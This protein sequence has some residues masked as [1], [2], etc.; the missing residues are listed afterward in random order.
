MPVHFHMLNH[1]CNYIAYALCMCYYYHYL[2]FIFN[3]HLRL[4]V[5]ERVLCDEGIILK[6]TEKIQKSPNFDEVVD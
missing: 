2:F 3:E 6:C 4:L 5:Y 1:P